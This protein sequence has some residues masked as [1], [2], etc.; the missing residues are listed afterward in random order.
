MEKV[1]T[2]EDPGNSIVIVGH[3]G[4]QCGPYVTKFPLR[5]KWVFTINTFNNIGIGRGS[6]TIEYE[7]FNCGVNWLELKNGKV[8]GPIQNGVSSLSI[9]D[10]YNLFHQKRTDH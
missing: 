5:T 1:L 8:E 10:F 3:P 2:G 7:L 6:N 4:S 9:K